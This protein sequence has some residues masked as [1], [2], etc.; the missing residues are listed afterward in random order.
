MV[1]F[2][3]PFADHA[4]LIRDWIPGPGMSVR[5]G[6][7]EFSPA[8]TESYCI[9]LTR[10]QDFRDFA[11]TV[12][13]RIVS[14][15]VGVVLRAVARTQYYM[16]QFDLK[17]DPSVVWFHTF[18]PFAQ[19]G[20]RLELVPSAQ[21][22]Q[23]G[24]WHRMRVVARDHTFQVFLGEVDGPLQYCASWHD[25]HQTYHEG[26]VGLWEHGG[27]AGEYRNLRVEALTDDTIIG[28]KAQETN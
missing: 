11:L 13:V 25:P 22:P 1:L 10:R 6:K 2:E 7:L 15:A 19:G 23:A 4:K 16:V 8:H 18:T 27:E 21:V 14:A 3:E 28:T 24:A 12:D 5:Q 9:G 20:Y 26:A 17:N